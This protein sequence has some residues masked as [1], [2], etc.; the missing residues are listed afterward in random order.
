MEGQF[1]VDD[2]TR[3]NVLALPQV[4]VIP[5]RISWSQY[6]TSVVLNDFSP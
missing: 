4:P 6:E 1:I 2:S 3:V 5:R